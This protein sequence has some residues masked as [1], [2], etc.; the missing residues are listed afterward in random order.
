VFAQAM[1]RDQTWTVAIYD[2]AR[3]VGEKR[4]SQIN[5]VFDGLLPKGY[6]RESF[7]GKAAHRLDAARIAELTRF[8]DHARELFD[9]PAISFGVLQ[10][11]KVVFAGGFGVREPGKPGKPDADTLYI[12]ASNTKALTTLLLAK[13]VDEH[14]LTWDTPVTRVMPSFKLGDD[15]TTRGVLVKH[16]IQT[17]ASV[18]G[19]REVLL[20]IYSTA[21]RP[22]AWAGIED[23]IVDSLQRP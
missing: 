20:R 10:D 18:L 6:E 3:A 5:A 23:P 17:W 14:R 1:R 9:V 11:G 16:L 13:L 22:S 12:I 8:V 21:D 2:V 7:A 19:D 4:G 15:A